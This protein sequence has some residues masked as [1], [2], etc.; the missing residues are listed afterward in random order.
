MT[1][2]N[3]DHGKQ[4]PMPAEVM[5]IAQTAMRGRRRGNLA[6][7]V[8]MCQMGP[9]QRRRFR[10]SIIRCP[11]RALPACPPRWREPSPGL[12]IAAYGNPWTQ[13]PWGNRHASHHDAWHMH[14]CH[15]WREPQPTT[16]TICGRILQG[17]LH[18]K[19]SPAPPLPLPLSGART[20][21][22]NIALLRQVNCA[23]PCGSRCPADK[24]L[25]IG[26]SATVQRAFI[27]P[28]RGEG[29]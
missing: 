27:V 2:P 24:G 22:N 21:H 8:E 3:Y 16:R 29:S 1:T 26:G 13:R 12:P 4:Q 14:L 6:G 9:K 17:W 28:R 10:P 15:Y 7:G 18:V 20:Q 25:T 19:T 23:R 11:R 5:S